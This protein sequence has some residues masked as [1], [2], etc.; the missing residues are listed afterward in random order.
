[1]A[2]TETLEGSCPNAGMSVSAA[3]IIVSATTVTAR[4]FIFHIWIFALILSKRI[5]ETVLQEI[6][7]FFAACVF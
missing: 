4:F 3:K 7:T 2:K 5:P 6:V 1:M